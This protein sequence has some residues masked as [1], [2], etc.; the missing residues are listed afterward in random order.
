MDLLLLPV[1]EGGRI[2]FQFVAFHCLVCHDP[3][4]IFVVFVFRVCV[5]IATA[6]PNVATTKPAVAT[7]SSN[8]ATA[9]ASTS[10]TEGG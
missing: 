1:R 9:V 6:T 8:V 5:A 2:A 4:S 7:A 10:G 3:F